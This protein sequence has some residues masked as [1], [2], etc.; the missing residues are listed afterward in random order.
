VLTE[1]ET[2]LAEVLG[3]RVPPP[4]RGRVARSD[5]PGPSGAG[6]VIRVGVAATELLDPDLASTR[7]EVVP[8]SADPRRVLRLAATVVLDVTPGPN[9]GR[10]E[11]LR[12]LDAA[13]YELDS[14]DLRSGVALRTGGDQGFLLDSLALG[15]GAPGSADAPA[16]T[17]RAEGWFWPVGVAGR[18]GRAIVAA[19]VREF[20]L[21][22]VLTAADALVAGGDPVELR[23]ALGASGTLRLQDGAA[24]SLPVGALALRLVAADGGAG[25]GTLT[26]DRPGP[27]G[28]ALADLVAGEARVT[29][30]PPADPVTETLVV[31]AHA[32]DDDGGERVGMELARFDLAV[33]P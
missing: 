18:S 28:H 15:P 19:L 5:G 9:G 11:V 7:P 21:P 14:P 30:T 27:D 22:V 33:A 1:F 20:R 26:G 32:R 12:G 16:L 17:V 24:S 6:P 10:L 31:H 8:G 13:L 4:F 2:R 25:D 23:I 29:C 3:S